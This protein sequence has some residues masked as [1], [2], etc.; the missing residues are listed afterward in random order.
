[1]SYRMD[2]KILGFIKKE[3]MKVSIITVVYNNQKT[4]AQA[5]QSVLNQDYTPIEYIIVDGASTDGTIEIIKSYDKNISKFLSEPDK[6]IYDAMNKGLKLATGDIIGILNSDDFYNNNHIISQIVDEFKN[7]NVDLVFGD[8]AYV[9]PNNLN[10]I[11]RYYSSAKF[12]PSKFEWGWMP[13]HPSCFLKREIY[14][15]Y[16]HFKTDYKIGA[17]YELLV[18]FIGKHKISYSYIPQLFVKM[19]TGGISNKNIITYWTLNKEVVRS[20]REN[21][22]NTNIFKILLKYLTKIW[23]V[24]K[25][26]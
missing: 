8:V 4:I 9:K 13:A 18:R 6:G 1:M 14:E 26:P 3:K 17:D 24:I 21:G 23:Q 11:I 25:L 20:C 12:H 2:F 16:G 10:K 22:I 5:I 7:K 19:R 15:K